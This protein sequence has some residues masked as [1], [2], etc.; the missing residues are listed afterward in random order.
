MGNRPIG[1]RE[2]AARSR[3]LVGGRGRYVG[4]IRIAGLLDAAFVRSPHGHAHIKAID[5]TA[6]RATTGVHAV[7]TGAEIAAVTGGYR[8]SNLL[9][10]SLKAPLQYPLALDTARF[11][12]EPVVMV[13]AETRAI[14]EDAARLVAVDWEP[15]P[16]LTDPEQA[17]SPHSTP[18]H[19]DHADNIA[20]HQNH[21]AGAVDDVFAAAAHVVTVDIDFG[22]HT[23]TP[24]ETRGII[25]DFEGSERRLTVHISHQTPHQMQIE[26]ARFLGLDEHRVRVI[27]PDVG[28]AF[29]IKQQLYGDELAVCAA[30]FLVGRPVRFI[31][32]RLES[33]LSDIQAREH[34][35]SA[36]MA[37]DAAGRIL[38]F[39]IDDLFAIGPYSQYP[40]SSIGETRTAVGLC[41]APYRFEAMRATTDVVFQTK[42]M[43][44][45][46]RGVGHPIA[47]GVTETLIEKGARAVGVDPVEFRRM[48]FL[49][50]GD[51]PY[52]SPN[53]TRFERLAFPYCLAALEKA[54]DLTALRAETERAR[55]EGRLLG[56]GFAAFVEQT[57]RGPAFYGK[58]G[59]AVTTRDG[60]TVR[61]EPSGLFR[62]LSSVTEQ[63]QGTEM[64]VR[65]VV[66]AALGVATADVEVLTGDT[67]VTQHGGGTWGSRS[68]A[69]GGEAA[70]RAAKRLRQELL[71]LAGGLTQ[72]AVETLDIR[73]REVVDGDT[74]TAL[75]SLRQLGETAHFRP[76]EL[77]G[78][79]QPR[80]S[81]TESFGPL[82]EPFRA[83]SGI[84][85][86]LVEI[87]EGTGIIRLLR[88]A[89]V[90]EA[91]RIVNPLLVDEQIRGGAVQGIGAALMEEC[92]YDDAG[93]LINNSFS[94]YLVPMAVDVPDIE[95]IHAD[96]PPLPTDGLGIAGVGEAGTVGA[97]AAVMNAVNDALSTRGA[98]LYAMPL[99]PQRVLKALGI[100]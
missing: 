60:A 43:S 87:D 10:P 9:Y 25:A 8:G 22:R 61:F 70:W 77:A 69:I 44:G 4:D 52:A 62:C 91:G 39:D 57:S 1:E 58:G 46:Y 42:G 72:R 64:G 65:Q 13:V 53:G 99:T 15:L 35:I 59:A 3:R 23:G 63:G 16:A 49:T 79:V 66:A 75:L 5:R 93:R 84:Q 89:V 100:I 41:G 2:P 85:M 24:L 97:A 55:A 14:A 50:D 32:D 37:V 92:G 80:L 73:G 83:G 36:R 71:E 29:G 81:A 34:R 7:L 68:M 90:H 33:M 11:H 86:A 27:C 67:A 21:V 48:N 18:L 30:S 17:R 19:G 40:R 56:L 88:H 94:S 45:H 96:G 54:I 26:F 38:G 98:S 12:G 28:G 76:Y 95:I 78:G 74:G 31:A 6:A 51:M 20:Y 47:C 82:D